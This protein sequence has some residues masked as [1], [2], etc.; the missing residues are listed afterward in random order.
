MF[1]RNKKV[2]PRALTW[3]KEEIP[4]PKECYPSKRNLWLQLRRQKEMCR[5]KDDKNCQA[6][7][8]KKPH[9]LQEH[10][11]EN[12]NRWSGLE[13]QRMA[14]WCRNESPRTYGVLGIKKNK[15]CQNQ[16]CKVSFTLSV[17]HQCNQFIFTTG[18]LP[19]NLS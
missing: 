12:S 11:G 2:G 16:T 1:K 7:I 13:F 10:K 6:N 9:A 8:E 19:L 3:Q 18:W 14:A 17:Y 4:F 5:E 15:G